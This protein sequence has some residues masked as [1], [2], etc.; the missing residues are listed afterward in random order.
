MNKIVTVALLMSLMTVTVIG[1]PIEEQ[2]KAEEELSNEDIA[3][4]AVCS[5]DGYEDGQ[6][7]P[8]D[9]QRDQ[10]CDELDKSLGVD[11]SQSTYH[12]AFIQGCI[13]VEGNTEEDCERSIE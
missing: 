12:Q 6:N 11:V 2:A 8:F 13:S 7:Y 9:Q 4:L 5:D 1:L 3:V 10:E